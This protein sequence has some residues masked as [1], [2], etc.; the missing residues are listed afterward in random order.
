VFTTELNNYYTTDAWIVAEAFI[1]D[2]S[3]GT[4]ILFTMMNVVVTVNVYT[5]IALATLLIVVIPSSTDHVMGWTA[6]TRTRTLQQRSSTNI[7]N[8]VS[9]FQSSSTTTIDADNNINNYN[10]NNQGETTKESIVHDEEIAVVVNSRRNFLAVVAL[11]VT[12]GIVV[13][14]FGVRGVGEGGEGGVVCS[15]PP[16][17]AA[18]IDPTID[19]PVIT[20]RVWLDIEATGNGSG[21]GIGSFSGRIVIGLFGQVTPKIVDNFVSLCEMNAYGGTSFYRV[22]SDFSIQ[23][24]AI[25]DPTG[26]SGK[27]AADLSSNNN[28]NGNDTTTAALFPDNY[29]IRHTKKGL[30]SMVSGPGGTVDS[31]FFI[32]VNDNGGWGDDRYAAIGIVEGDESIELIRKIELV[33]VKPPTNKPVD[34]IMIVRSGVL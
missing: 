24:G 20:K 34:P 28:G 11:G 4:H 13:S 30:V 22:I 26:R 33:K 7:R 9:C 16:A 18:Y 5:F 25:G 27:T 8:T 15:P 32:N 29:N 10:D 19:T 1:F 21:K 17:Y 23:G 3:S 6:T 12:S 31:R 2:E 14:D